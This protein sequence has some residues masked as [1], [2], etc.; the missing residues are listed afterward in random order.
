MSREEGGRE[1]ERVSCRVRVVRVWR[2]VG[3]WIDIWGCTLDA[4]WAGWRKMWPA[5]PVSDLLELAELET[6]ICARGMD[7]GRF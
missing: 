4:E 5:G 6:T 2:V 7:L 3:E 1:G